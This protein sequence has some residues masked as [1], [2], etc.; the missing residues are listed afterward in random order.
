MT[1]TEPCRRMSMQGD[2]MPS[3]ER[4]WRD[5]HFAALHGN[6]N[7]EDCYRLLVEQRDCTPEQQAGDD[8]GKCG[9]CNR[10]TVHQYARICMAC[11]A[12]YGK[13]KK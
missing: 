13:A 10:F 6:A 5:A 11:G 12:D 2:S 4:C 7:K 3:C 8:A 9:P 1:D